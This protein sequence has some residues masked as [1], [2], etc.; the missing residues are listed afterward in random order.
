MLSIGAPCR[1]ADLENLYLT[2][3]WFRLRDAAGDAKTADFYRGALAAAF[4]DPVT[5]ERYLSA[6]MKS[7]ADVTQRVE[8]GLLLEEMYARS[9][10]RKSAS[11]QQQ[12]VENLVRD[13]VG[14]KAVDRSVYRAFQRTRA[15]TA[16]LNGA[17]D[18]TVVAR[19]LS[20]VPYTQ[21]DN[22]IVLPLTVNGT[23]ANYYLD[24]GSEE[25]FLDE[26]EAKRLGLTIH[27]ASIPLEPYGAHSDLTATG[28]ALAHDL[29]IGN[30]HLRDVAFLV[31]K[32]NGYDGLLG[33]PLL[34]ALETLRWNSD[35]TLDIGFPPQ[36]RKL[37]D[38]NLCLDGGQLVTEAAFGS[39]K[40]NLFVDTGTYETLLFP[41]FTRQFAKAM[42][43]GT[44]EA[45]NI[46]DS[47][48][49]PEARTLSALT[50]RVGGADV[51]AGRIHALSRNFTEDGSWAH[52]NMGTD[53]A[54]NAR[55]V[56]L[57]F[58]AMRLTIE[59]GPASAGSAS[60]CTLPPDFTCLGGFACTVR[61]DPDI[62][63]HVDRV[64]LDEPAG[65]PLA[66]PQNPEGASSCALPSH[67][68]CGRDEICTAAFRGQGEC[69]IERTHAGPPPSTPAPRPS[70]ETKVTAPPTPAGPDAR[71]IVERS[72]K[73]ESLDMTPAKDYVYTDDSV[74]SFFDADGKV[75]ST[76]RETKEVMTLYD[77]TYERLLKKD[78][79]PLSPDKER[80]EQA[81]FDKAVE[82]RSHET[83]DAKARREEAERKNAAQE[84]ACS[85]EFLKWS[86]FRLEGTGDINGRPVW[87]IEV[88]SRPGASSTCEG[89][90]IL[91][92]LH[93]RLWIDQAEYRWA[94]V[95]GENI[96]A[97][98]WGKILLRLPVGALHFTFQQ[99]RLRE[100]VWMASK[101]DARVDPR[102]M[103]FA[104]LHLQVTDTFSNYRK[105]QSDSRIVPLGEAR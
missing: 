67:F 31:V 51:T 97:I 53:F 94:Q 27:P 49:D 41:T 11:A 20:R 6:V 101:D 78:G 25:S 93:F 98:T 68:V 42:E 65:N 24:T 16:A 36:P 35:G 95:Q 2:S 37:A 73:F 102:L 90:K 89:A 23:S 85:N 86:T 43:A 82:K 62:R 75:K 39:Q 88:N 83:P 4:N 70:T 76:V 59:G 48:R 100:G 91:A 57:D 9:G 29:V 92:K 80:A 96:A 58:Q 55:S 50:L 1:A 10:R 22:Q 7:G 28:V 81:R 103:I 17:A 52:G 105:F 71:E 74:E 32:D 54:G 38:A 84:L 5:A 21:I 63:C 61:Y 33:L 56:T 60:A 47:N 13:L 8:A 69:R 15:E 44:P 30:V 104:K 87:I 79:K 12:R 34:M 40:L 14:A 72:L 99:M 77:Q 18:Q 19:R 45:F 3:Q 46:S 26:S 64:P 66:K